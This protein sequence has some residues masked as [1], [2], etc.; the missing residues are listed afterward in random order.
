VWG[1]PAGEQWIV[2][3][4]AKKLTDQRTSPNQRQLL[5][6][7]HYP[8]CSCDG[9]KERS[10]GSLQNPSLPSP[11]P[12][13]HLLER[14][15]NGPPPNARCDSR[16]SIKI[17]RFATFLFSR[18]DFIPSHCHKESVR[19][20]IHGHRLGSGLKLAGVFCIRDDPT[21]PLL[22]RFR[23]IA[24]PS[25]SDARSRVRGHLRFTVSVTAHTPPEGLRG[26][27]GN[28]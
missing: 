4:R 18:N 15:K 13:P 17:C 20:S 7:T 23:P 2:T 22:R 14:G 3:T 28:S 11:N 21:P 27:T 19:F 26:R 8:V 12:L 16:R 6:R 24:R 10:G 1:P 25:S 5:T 9:T